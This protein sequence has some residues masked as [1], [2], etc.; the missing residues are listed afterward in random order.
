MSSMHRFTASLVS[1]VLGTL[2]ANCS[3]Y[4]SACEH[5]QTCG[6]FPRGG[7]AGT[8]GQAGD[9]G[10]SG[11][12]GKS[13]SGG[14][15]SS[16]G[17]G[18]TGGAA[19]A[20]IGGEGGTGTVPKPC[21]GPCPSSTPICKEATD[22]C[23]ECLTSTDCKAPGKSLCDVAANG[24]VACL[25]DADCPSATASRCDAGV[26]KACMEKD[27]MSCSHIAGKQL[28]SAG[29]CV[30]CT[31]KDES[32]CGGKSCNPATLQ[33]TNT[34]VASRDLCQSCIADRDP[35]WLQ[36]YLCTAGISA[37]HASPTVS[38]S[39]VTKLSRRRMTGTGRS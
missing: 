7:A 1:V 15:G 11:I 9:P 18:N 13:G 26:C 23:V 16:S 3:G 2:I 29:A 37:S 34:P 31:T 5:S 30:Q 20:G 33:C 8:S 36:E 38:A 14:G 19:E 6:T 17:G 22:E 4:D 27:D 25:G 10:G 35:C 12:S 28:C 24:C 32:A 21:G 39:A